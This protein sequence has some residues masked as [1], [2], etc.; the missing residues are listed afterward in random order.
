MTQTGDV[1]FYTVTRG[2]ALGIINAIRPDIFLMRLKAMGWHHN[3][4]TTNLGKRVHLKIF[5]DVLD[6]NALCVKFQ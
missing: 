6:K 2:L 5:I 1:L 4:G 3:E